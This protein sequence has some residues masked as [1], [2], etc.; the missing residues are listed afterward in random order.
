MKYQIFEQILNLL[1]E[2]DCP[3][4]IGLLNSISTNVLFSGKNIVKYLVRVKKVEY[5][6]YVY[7]VPRSNDHPYAL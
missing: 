7:I 5:L 4:Q 3:V 6:R 2:F 1:K